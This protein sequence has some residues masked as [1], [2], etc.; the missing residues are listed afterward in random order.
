V[1]SL[2]IKTAYEFIGGWL[3]DALEVPS[4]TM[5]NILADVDIYVDASVTDDPPAGKFTVKSTVFSIFRD[6]KVP[7]IQTKLPVL[8]EEEALRQ[9]EEN[10]EDIAV[11]LES[12]PQEQDP[13]PEP[14]QSS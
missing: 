6:A 3:K 5:E 7:R 1:E 10:M 13:N 12:S 2:A 4:K 9:H 11:Q 14:L 8:S